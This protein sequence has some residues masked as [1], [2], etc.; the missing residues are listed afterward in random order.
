MA[1]AM[2]CTVSLLRSWGC[3]RWRLFQVVGWE[4]SGGRCDF[5]SRGR[6]GRGT[7]AAL[8]GRMLRL[9][10]AQASASVPTLALGLA[11]AGQPMAA[12]PTCAFGGFA[13]RSIGIARRSRDSWTRGPQRLKPQSVSE[14]QRCD[15]KSHPCRSC[16]RLSVENK[17]KPSGM[18][19]PGHREDSLRRL[20]GTGAQKSF[21]CGCSLRLGRKDQSSLK[22]TS[23]M[24]SSG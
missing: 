18:G 12:V 11:C 8:A 23:M 3:V 21:D 13:A 7:L 22:M 5:G 6:G 15:C 14:L 24:R 20:S 2:G 4:C 10:S 1:C 9:R 19:E 16:F 17:S